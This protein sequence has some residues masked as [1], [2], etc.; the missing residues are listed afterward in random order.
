MT[1]NDPQLTRK[2][3]QRRERSQ[4]CAQIHTHTLLSTQR[5]GPVSKLRHI[6]VLK[7][8]SWSLALLVHSLATLT[9]SVALRTLFKSSLTQSAALRSARS[10]ITLTPPCDNG[11][12]VRDKGNIQVIV[13]KI[14]LKRERNNETK[15]ET[16]RQREKQ[17]DKDRQRNE[18]RDK[19]TKIETKMERKRRG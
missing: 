7:R 12:E 4:A 13:T 17:K 1:L 15:I 2:T 5:F 11:T 10:L 9:H 16:K 8:V 3:A 18:N 14:E 19:E 6:R